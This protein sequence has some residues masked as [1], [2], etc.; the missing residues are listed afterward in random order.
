MGLR[1]V[2]GVKC[3][4]F[5]KHINHWKRPLIMIFKGSGCSQFPEAV[6]TSTAKEG[7]RSAVNGSLQ[8][9]AV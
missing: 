6:A 2:G 4:P 1:N 7:L 5:V 3:Q 9:V 8:V